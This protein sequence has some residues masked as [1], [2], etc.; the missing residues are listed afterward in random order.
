MLWSTAGRLSASSLCRRLTA[1]TAAAAA[2]EWSASRAVPAAGPAGVR[3][4]RPKL[5]VLMRLNCSSARPWRALR[6]VM[7][8]IRRSHD[9]VWLSTPRLVPSVQRDSAAIQ[10]SKDCTVPYSLVSNT[11]AKLNSMF[12]CWFGCAGVSQT[13][14][15]VWLIPPL[16]CW[17]HCH[18]VGGTGLGKADDPEL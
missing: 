13:P 12:V 8:K 15:I 10:V 16:V 4:V 18:R 11:S 6:V 9:A 5:N 17:Q 2:V 1:T 14:T 7:V 3:P